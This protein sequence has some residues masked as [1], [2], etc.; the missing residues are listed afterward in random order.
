M[1]PTIPASTFKPVQLPQAEGRDRMNSRTK[2]LL[3]LLVAAGVLGAIAV[4]LWANRDSPEA[5]DINQALATIENDEQDIDEFELDGRWTVGTTQES[6]AGVR[7]DEELR[8][9]GSVT[10]VLRTPDVSG[11]AT[12]TDQTLTDLSIAVDLT[13]LSSDDPR[14]DRSVARAL[15]L[16]SFPIATFTFD[17]AVDVTSLADGSQVTFDAPGT[18]TINGVSRPVVASGTVDTSVAFIVAVAQ[19]PVVFA[20]F[21]VDL[22]SAPIVLSLADNG[23]IEIQLLFR[24]S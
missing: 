8:G 10:A 13:T 15:D 6:F 23:I 3:V 2:T 11:E 4:A 17:G 12:I 19:I 20:D 7:V 9:L 21:A 1:L 5:V 24:R 18:L 14:R 16:V 22:P